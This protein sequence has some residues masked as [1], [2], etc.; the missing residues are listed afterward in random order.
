MILLKFTDNG[1]GEK[2]NLLCI[3]YNLI[4]LLCGEIIEG[5]DFKIF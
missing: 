3:N 1:G 4:S 2:V 5:K